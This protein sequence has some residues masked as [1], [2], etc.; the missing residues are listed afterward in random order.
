[1]KICVIGAGPAGLMAS[2]IASKKH[3]VI[4]VDSQNN[5][6]TKLLM[7]GNGRCNVTNN[8]TIED[9][10][11]FCSRSSKFLYSS[12]NTFGPKEI[13]DFFESRNVPLHQEDNQRMFP[14]SNNSRDILN[15]LVKENKSTLK[16]NTYI[17]SFEIKNNRIVAALTRDER[18][19]ADHFILCTGGKSFPSTGSDGSGYSLAKQCGHTVTKLLG[20][21][22]GLLADNTEP[23][24]G[25]SLNTTIQVL[26]KN[27]VKFEE[28]GDILFTHF[29]LSGPLILKAS[30]FVVDALDKNHPV[31][32]KILLGKPDLSS[33]PLKKQLQKVAPKRLV[34][35]L[36]KDEPPID[37]LEQT[38]KLEKD[39]ILNTLFT[40]TYLINGTIP[41]EKAFVTRG[42][43]RT[44]EID[45]KTM[46][47]KLIDNLS[48]CG[49]VIDVHGMLGGFNI[50]IAL[51]SGYTAGSSV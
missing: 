13:I 38:S 3:E 25:L 33:G 2:L 15:A 26:T 12:L 18:I 9:F 51:S 6:G 49:E 28:K 10:L 37:H 46:K 1:M 23:L 21:E 20:V 17:K 44:N 35:F 29:G 41:I 31:E 22:V 27:K 32:I 42:G 39:R 30:E 19:E 8:R 7:T 45:P 43:V 5:V 16:L 4:L 48:L 11:T 34:E 36:L 40:L 24:M 47:S 14:N 50:S